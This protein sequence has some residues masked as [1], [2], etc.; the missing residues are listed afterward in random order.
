MV[1][2]GLEIGARVL[3]LDRASTVIIGRSADASVI[4]T[5]PLA[6]RE[7]LSVSFENGRWLARDLHTLNGTYHDGAPIA[8]GRPI[9]LRPGMSLM[10]GDPAE[11][12]RIRV[13]EAHNPSP[14][15]ASDPPDTDL[16]LGPGISIVSQQAG[17]GGRCIAFAARL[18]TITI[19]RATDNSII[20]HDPMVSAHHAKLTRQ[21]AGC[22]LVEDLRSTNGTFVDGI[23]INHV[24][25][26]LG[27]VVSVGRVFLKVNGEG[28]TRIAT[29]A[30]DSQ[31]DGQRATGSRISLSVS[32]VTFSVGTDRREQSAGLGPRKKLL[33]QVTF[34][35][36]QRSL[37]AVIGPSGAGKSTMLKTMVGLLT[38]DSGQVLFDG[39]D[40]A[41]FAGSVANRVGMVPQDDLVHPEL[42]ARR[43]LEY[44]A[45][46]R[47]PDDSTPQDRQESVDWAIRELGLSQ[48]A[49]T[50]ISRLS[51]GQRKRVS[52]AMELLTKPDLLFLDEPTSGLDPNLD[53]EVMELLRDLAHGT[54]QTPS[55]RTVVVITH[56]TDNLDKADSV[57]LLAPGGKVAFFG[58]PDRLQGYFAGALA[59]D[60]SYSNIYGLI[61]KQP[62]WAQATFAA[63]NLVQLPTPQLAQDPAVHYTVAAPRK[64]LGRQTLTLLGRQTRLVASDRS[65]LLFTL[66]L[67]IVMG[68]LTAAVQAANGFSAATTTKA[69]GDP[70]VLLVVVVFGSV[71][72]GMVPS[73]RQLVGE[74]AIFIHEA[75]AGVRPLAY[76]TSK[77]VLLGLVCSVQSM[78]LIAVTL[79]LNNHPASGVIWP[80]PLELFAVALGTSWTCA[81]LGLLLSSLVRTSEQVMPLMVVVLMLQ[82]VMSGG[83]LNVLAPGINEM[84]MLAPSRWGFAA[85]ASS[86][87]FNRTIFCNAQVMGKSKED[88][89]VNRKTKE[90][91]DEA[92]QE[93][94]DQANANGMPAPTLKEAD[95]QHTVVDC[96][97]VDDQ[98]RLW[99]HDRGS[100]LRNLTALAYYFALYCGIT[101]FALLWRLKR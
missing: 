10:L 63:S 86:L 5:T 32:S 84:S 90:A 87:D 72:M 36:P 35:V 26:G 71:L 43:A 81:A 93:A 49:D 69:V 94:L 45:R 16:T 17:D 40:M 58:P 47:F 33:D 4:L 85:G 95:V 89:E 1:E 98:D 61:A 99:D 7:H 24:E 75:G 27:A 52:T 41:V 54:A 39:L 74:R 60:P 55:G 78:L 65:L 11:G 42:S 96:A 51:G 73:V 79:L 12:E 76:L 66:A 83:V 44:A 92:N 77:V 21:V 8:P 13:I 80:L 6:S 59:T 20:I 22:Y 23:R 14:Q 28:F 53:R 19:G 56:S 67:P 2:M 25:V 68:L 30:S 48:H 82:L 3:A 9:E 38:P 37:L 100:W 97:T 31:P 101:Y 18:D 46:L 64:R 57:L 50:R 29:G 88:I 62:E 34:N 15:S 91:T 70:R